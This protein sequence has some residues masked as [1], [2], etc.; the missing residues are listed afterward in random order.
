ML[1]ELLDKAAV[2]P[3]IKW[4]RVL[5][6]YPERITEELIDTML[7]HNTIAKYIDMPIQHFCNEI[8]EAMNRRNT[9]ESTEKLID[10]IRAKSDDFILRT[11][12]ITG[13]PGETRQDVR[14]VYDALLK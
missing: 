12:L 1:T 7:K 14:A 4:L 13:F 2:I 6:C 10:M 11:T 9:Y 5:Y 8:L 3:G